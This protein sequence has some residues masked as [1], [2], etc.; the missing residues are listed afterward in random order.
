[1]ADIEKSKPEFVSRD[2]I[3]AN[4][5]YIQ[6]LA[7][8]KKRFRESQARATVKVNTEMLEFYWSIGRD[9]VNLR[10]ESRWGAGVVKQF[11]LDMRETFPDS[12]GFS[13]TNVK[14]MKRWYLFYNERDAKSQR[15]VD[16]ISQQVGDLLFRELKSQQVADHLG[17]EEK[18][19]QPADQLEMPGIF[20][21]VPWFH[22]VIIISKAQSL[23][24]ALF[25]IGKV[26]SEGWSRAFLEHQMDTHLYETQGSAIRYDLTNISERVS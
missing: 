10:A 19:Q 15:P 5:D 1:M 16:Q 4:T 13:Y 18:S 7:D 6:W 11:A 9:L 23:D 20:G 21:Q 24:E 3:I 12:T 14:Y 17:K 25:Y 26:I 8:V 2:G 22:H